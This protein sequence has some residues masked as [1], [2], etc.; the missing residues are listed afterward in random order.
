M[1]K[2]LVQYAT[3]YHCKKDVVISQL[4]TN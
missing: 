1:K 3:V 2:V 4:Y